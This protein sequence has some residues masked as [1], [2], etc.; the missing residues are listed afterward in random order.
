MRIVDVHT[1]AFPDKLAARAIA[2]LQQAGHDQPA[3]NGTVA[4]L[5][6]SMD[7]AGV[8]V[9]VVCSIATR[10]EQFRSI[11][12]WSQQIASERIVPFPSIHPA[13]PDAAGQVTELARAGFKGFKLH[14]YYQEFDI[15]EPRLFPLYEK[16]AE[17]GL[18]LLCHAGFDIAFTRTRRA[19]PQRIRRVV[20]QFPTLNFIASHMGAWEDWDEVEPWLIGTNVF[21]DT[22]FALDRLPASQARHLLMAHRPDRLLF[23]TDSPWG[24]QQVE[25]DR[26]R[27]LDLPPSLLERV[28]STNALALLGDDGR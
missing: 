9:S 6:C 7:A 2:H 20:E 15:D 3:L 4:D 12:D 23:G 22:S 5:L 17:H 28:L 19:K 16:A 11:L 26:L 18:V 27:Q 1:H 10:P 24:D 8:A 21:L 14:P 13:H 25:I